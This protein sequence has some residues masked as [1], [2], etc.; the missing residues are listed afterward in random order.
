MTNKSCTDKELLEFKKNISDQ[1]NKLSEELLDIKKRADDMLKSSTSTFI[2][3]PSLIN[4]S[5]VSLSGL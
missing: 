1:R 5:T 4:E 2:I 3:Y